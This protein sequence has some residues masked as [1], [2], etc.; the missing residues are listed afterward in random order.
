MEERQTTPPATG[1]AGRELE[2]LRAVLACPTYGP[3]DPRCAKSIR[4]AMMS[5]AKHGLSWVGD[6]STDRMGWGVGRNTSAQFAFQHDDIDGIVWVDSDMIVPPDGISRLLNDALW[7]PADFVTAV[8]HQRSP[9]YTPVL[10]QWKP[11]KEG[12][13][14]VEEYTE[15]IFDKVDGCGFGLVWTSAKL[16]RAIAA[17]P[18]FD[19]AS[20]G[21]FPDKRDAG[22]FGEDLGFCRYAMLAGFQL[23]ADSGIQPGHVGEG[24]VITR[25]DWKGITAEEV[26]AVAEHADTSTGWGERK[27]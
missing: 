15:G 20:G 7:W 13:A 11:D 16:I 5:A 22:G 4:V 26:A 21:W 10:F 27:R 12:F 19:H 6:V 2:G 17:L 9:F 3:V 23:W 1:A 24:R 14:P 8:Y 25:K 18:D